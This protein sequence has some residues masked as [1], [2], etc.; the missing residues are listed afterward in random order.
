MD[1][2]VMLPAFQDRRFA[3]AALEVADV[4]EAQGF[5][6]GVAQGPG[7]QNNGRVSAHGHGERPTRS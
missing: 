7:G 4:A 1:D 5:P 3:H 6:D 2:P